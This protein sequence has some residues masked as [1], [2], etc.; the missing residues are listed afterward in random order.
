MH[1]MTLKGKQ[2]GMMSRVLGRR[3]VVSAAA[4]ALSLATVAGT[5]A[6]S[7]QAVDRPVLK[8]PF[9]C[10]ETWR[11][12]AWTGHNPYYAIDFNQGSGDDDFG[13]PVKASAGGTVLAAG[14]VGS[15]YGYRV[16]IGHGN[17]W[18]TLYAHLQAGSL[19]VQQGDT[20]SATTTIGR[21]GKSGGQTYSHLHYEQRYNGNDVAIR[22][23]SSTW[24]D[25]PSERYYTRT[26]C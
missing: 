25:Y 4:A 7:A 23:G 1:T 19:T 20:V 24:V 8:V 14:D 21:V 12:N 22:F 26:N 3:A 9:P 5:S 2:T 10:N 17:G 11:G 18:S 15:G 6:M 16:I 13:R